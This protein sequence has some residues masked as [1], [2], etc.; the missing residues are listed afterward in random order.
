MII[1]FAVHEMVGPLI[2]ILILS[3]KALKVRKKTDFIFG[4]YDEKYI[5]N[6]YSKY[7]IRRELLTMNYFLLT[8]K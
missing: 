4:L 5:Y 1:S 8:N 3:A 7:F 6:D 2:E